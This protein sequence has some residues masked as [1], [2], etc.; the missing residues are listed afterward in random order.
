MYFTPAEDDE[1][2][3]PICEWREGSVWHYIRQRKIGNKVK[4][5]QQ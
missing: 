3:L 2:L 5:E 4:K 1:M